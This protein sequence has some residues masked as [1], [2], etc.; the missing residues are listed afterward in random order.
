MS[1][2]DEFAGVEL[3]DAR[4]EK[5]LA[6]ILPLLA[7]T[8]DASFPA[9]M[10]SDANSEALYRFLSNAKVSLDGLLAPHIAQTVARA[11][12][13][14]LVRVVHDTS[15]FRFNGEREQLGIF[16]HNKRGFFGHFA[17]VVGDGEE[18]NPLG[19]ARLETYIH[20]NA[21]A[22]RGKTALERAHQTLAKSHAER[23]SSRW[24][25]AALEVAALLPKH[26]RAI[27]LMDREGGGYDIMAPLVASGV[28]FVVRTN[29]NRLSGKE[30]RDGKRQVPSPDRLPLKE[31]L[32]KSPTTIFRTVHLARREA[33]R[34]VVKKVARYERE[35]TLQIRWAAAPMHVPRSSGTSPIQQ[36]DLYAV[37]VFEEKPPPGQEAVEWMLLTTEPVTNLE[38]ATAIVDHYRARWLIEEYF[39]ALKTGCS[40]EKRQLESLDTLLPA[41]ALFVP[42]AWHLL[43]LRYLSR[44]ESPPAA[45]V[46]FSANQ[47]LILRRLIEH[48][49]PSHQL[50][51]TP[52]AR[53]LALAIAKLG[54]HLTN[55]GAPGWLVLGR[56]FTRFLEAEAVWNLALRSDQ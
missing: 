38:Q 17:L 3:G 10:G 18:R 51:V 7:A 42:I 19:V 14:T 11:S 56:G 8:P 41:L 20:E 35:A 15:A 24:D 12:E 54:G 44:Q 48:R 25:R 22:N 32:A 23:E 27:H 49:D 21:I 33:K 46:I 50:P 1:V 13:H 37:H 28:S 45:S 2:V 47:L 9:Q 34:G 5:R 31:L 6:T 39:K 52:N 30:V 40:Y 26:V 16:R 43:Q 29:P 55:N 4:L 53:D 36:L